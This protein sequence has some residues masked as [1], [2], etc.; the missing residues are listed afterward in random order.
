MIALLFTSNIGALAY[1]YVLLFCVGGAVPTICPPLF[2]ANVFGEKDYGSL[3]GI[4]NVAAGL[5]AAVGSLLCGG[6]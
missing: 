3:V 6:I 5:G 1:V 4:L 2:V